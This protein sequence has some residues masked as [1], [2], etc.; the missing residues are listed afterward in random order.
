MRVLFSIFIE[1]RL[2]RWD[3]KPRPPAFKAVALQTEPPRQPT[4]AAQLVGFKS[5]KLCK[6]KRLI[7]PDKQGKLKLNSYFVPTMTAVSTSSCVAVDIPS[8]LR[9]LAYAAIIIFMHV[10]E[11]DELAKH[12]PCSLSGYVE[13]SLMLQYNNR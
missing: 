13:A 6:V 2:L 12:V 4:K 8:R 10:L 9:G 5:H 11:H 7:I 3:L 1:K